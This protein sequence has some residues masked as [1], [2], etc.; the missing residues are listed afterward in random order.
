MALS[1]SMPPWFAVKTT[2]VAQGGL[3]QM[4]HV[5][6][7]VVSAAMDQSIAVQAAC[8]TAMPL[9]SVANLQHLQGKLAH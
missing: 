8:Q 9:P 1:S 5:V 7:R 3:A 6:A 4:E 2:L